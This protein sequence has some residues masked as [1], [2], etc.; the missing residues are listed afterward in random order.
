MTTQKNPVCIY[1]K[2]SKVIKHGKTSTGNRRYRC[3]NCNKTW[4]IEKAQTIRPDIAE[5]VEAY[6]NGKTC[7]DLVGIY[8]SSPLRIN[9]KIR[10]FLD[11]CPNWEE[12]I[13]AFVPNHDTKLI[14]LTGRE[15]SCSTGNSKDNSMYLALAIDAISTLVLGFEIDY[16]ESK[17]I[18]FKMLSRMNKRGITCPT[19]MS[20]GSKNIEDAIQE[21]YP[22]SA[23]RIFYH[24]AFRDKELMCCLA[25]LPINNKLI[26]D[27]IN[28]FDSLKFRPLSKYL[29]DIGAKS[30]KEIIKNNPEMYIKRLKE[31]LNN[32][33]QI[34]IEGLSTAFKTRFEKFHMLKDNPYPLINGWIARWMLSRLDIGYSRTSIYAQIPCVTTFKRFS[35][36]QLP[37]P[38]ILKDGSLPLKTFVI[39]LACRSV[40]LPTYY[41]KCEMKLDKCS[42]F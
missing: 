35:C 25:R 42:L 23:I 21:T 14:Y 4:V 7:R 40:Q 18:W 1:C 29:K 5:I 33:H 12:Y 26:N 22:N 20:N 3:R 2:S 30:V 15:F 32:R 24:K 28:A 9:Q 41:S 13:D 36:G 37:T 38:I 17:N 16:K 10:E 6:L 27:G 11:G 19:F 31:R 8:H 34:R 39:E